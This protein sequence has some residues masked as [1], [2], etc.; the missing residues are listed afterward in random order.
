MKSMII[1]PHLQGLGGSTHILYSTS[2]LYYRCDI[3]IYMKNFLCS[4]ALNVGNIVRDVLAAFKFFEMA[5]VAAFFRCFIAGVWSKVFFFFFFEVMGGKNFFSSYCVAIDYAWS[6]KY[7]FFKIC[8]YLV[9]IVTNL[10]CN[11]SSCRRS[12]A[13]GPS[14]SLQHH[15]PASPAVSSGALLLH[16]P[17]LYVC[18]TIAAG[19]L[20]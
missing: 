5:F 3:S 11:A 18:C 7:N 19:L 4:S 12:P 2:T 16:A 8:Q 14:Q 10:S 9:I 6:I 15:V 17:F 20:G 1:D 13:S